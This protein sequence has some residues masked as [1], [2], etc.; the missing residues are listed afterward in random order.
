MYGKSIIDDILLLG[1]RVVPKKLRSTILAI[2]HKGHPGICRTKQLARE[3]V[4]WKWRKIS[5]VSFTSA[6]LAL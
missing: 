1:D 4:Y 2:L 5:N 6:I 3:Y